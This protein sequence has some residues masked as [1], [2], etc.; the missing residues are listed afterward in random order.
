MVITENTSTAFA[1][2]IGGDAY[3]AVDGTVFA[4]DTTRVGRSFEVENEIF[5]TGDDA[6]Y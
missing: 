4:A 6:I 3:T 1:I 5:G 2:N